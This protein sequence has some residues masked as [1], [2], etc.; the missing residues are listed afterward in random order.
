MSDTPV[1]NRKVLFRP[2]E[3]KPKVDIGENTIF[4]QKVNENLW[5]T[6]S[7]KLKFKK[8]KEDSIQF[9]IFKTEQE[10][11]KYE[12]MLSSPNGNKLDINC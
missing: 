12:E 2:P 7:K 3:I 9:Q 1:N 11:Q 6:A 4:S 8:P 5:E 10:T